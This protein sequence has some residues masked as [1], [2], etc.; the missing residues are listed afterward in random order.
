MCDYSLE[1][2]PSRPAK[3]GDRLISTGFQHTVT[4]GFASVE[5]RNVVVCLLPGTE[6]AFQDDVRCETGF[7]FSRSVGQKAATFRQINRSESNCHHDA[8]E[9]PDGKIVL[10]TSLCENQIAT[11]LQLPAAT[12]PANLEA[13]ERNPKRSWVDQGCVGRTTVLFT[14]FVRQRETRN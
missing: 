6:L 2:V 9:F 7:V 10:L 4:R 13:A 5:D 14:D 11:V 8:L 3:V 1:L 12:A